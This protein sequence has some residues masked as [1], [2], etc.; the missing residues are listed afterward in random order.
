MKMIENKSHGIIKM[1]QNNVTSQSSNVPYLS[2]MSILL[3][4]ICLLD[5][6]SLCNVNS[7]PQIA[8]NII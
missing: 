1:Q 3:V 2:P 5:S 8:T 4:S 7:F 6:L